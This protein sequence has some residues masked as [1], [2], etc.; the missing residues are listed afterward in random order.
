MALSVD[1]V[2][3]EA[4]IGQM[5]SCEEDISAIYTDMQS[6]VQSLVNNGYMEAEAAN[7]Y[8]DEFNEMLS[9][10]IQALKDLVAEYYAQ[11]SK[12][13]ANFADADSKIASSLF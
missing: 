4:L 11:L 10:D 5:Q 9:P 12:I 7:A 13:C 8:V 1:Y 3:V 2:Q 6:T